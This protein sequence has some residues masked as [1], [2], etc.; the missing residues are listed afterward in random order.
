MKIIYY[1]NRNSRAVERRRRS[2]CT[3]QCNNVCRDS[4]RVRM[5]HRPWTGEICHHQKVRLLLIADAVAADKRERNSN[6]ALSRSSFLHLITRHARAPTCA[7]VDSL[8][9]RNM[10]AL[11]CAEFNF[12]SLLMFA[13]KIRTYIVSSNS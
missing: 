1:H 11:L 3:R 8:R 5:L 12:I 13:N 6:Y 2:V 9:S 4:S 7:R 10:S